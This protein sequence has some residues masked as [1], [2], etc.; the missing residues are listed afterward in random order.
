MQ[1]VIQN[2]I[3]KEI[4]AKRNAGELLRVLRGDQKNDERSKD[5]N[6][7]SKNAGQIFDRVMFLNIQ[8]DVLVRP[9]RVQDQADQNF[10][11]KDCPV[12]PVLPGWHERMKAQQNCDLKRHKDGDQIQQ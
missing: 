1:Q 3:E 12:Q 8:E 7:A 4:V 2:N 9:V 10:E 11:Q 5:N 6:R